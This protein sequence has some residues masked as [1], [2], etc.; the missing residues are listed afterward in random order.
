[1]VTAGAHI[2]TLENT[3]YVI[4]N[5]GAQKSDV[6]VAMRCANWAHPKHD[7]RRG[8]PGGART[9]VLLD[10]QDGHRIDTGGAAGGE[11]CRGKSDGGEGG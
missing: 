10:L 6:F 9:S 7:C 4:E 2:D 5:A 1:V 3:S 8:T 11:K